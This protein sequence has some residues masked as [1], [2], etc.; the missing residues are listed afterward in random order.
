MKEDTVELDF[1]VHGAF[2]KS[3]AKELQNFIHNHIYGLRCDY[4][5]IMK[6]FCEDRNYFLVQ[7]GTTLRIYK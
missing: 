4:Y 3:E 5:G 6:K 2:T 1:D 7:E